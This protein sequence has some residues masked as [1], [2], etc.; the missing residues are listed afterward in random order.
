LRKWGIDKDFIVVSLGGGN[1]INGNSEVEDELN[2]LKRLNAKSISVIFDGERTSSQGKLS[3][4]LSTFKKTCENLNFNV[5]P[6]DLHS[7][8]NYISQR[9]LDEVLGKG[10]KQLKPY[11][12]FNSSASKWSKDKN[13]LLFREMT[14]EELKGTK[15]YD[16]IE[17]TLFPLAN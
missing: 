15:L 1:F 17:E 11:E 4:K 6:T 3:S 16:F 8:E 5:F 14:K 13:W 10:F 7:T 12:S 9:A 2:E